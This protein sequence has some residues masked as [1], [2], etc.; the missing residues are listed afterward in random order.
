LLNEPVCAWL[1]AGD[2]EGQARR[3][4]TLRGPRRIHVAFAIGKPA[5]GA[6]M[7]QVN[8]SRHDRATVDLSGSPAV[9]RTCATATHDSVVRCGK[10]VNDG[11]RHAGWR[12]FH[13]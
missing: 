5:I 4:R 9:L 3:A 12:L 10:V 2:P 13:V 11:R 6:T 1:F 7:I 8:L